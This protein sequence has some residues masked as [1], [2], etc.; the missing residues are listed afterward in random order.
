MIPCTTL[1]PTFAFPTM[2][3]SKQP[4][5]RVP[6]ALT[7]A[8]TRFLRGQ[9]HQLKTLLQTG[10]KGLTD[11]FL[12]EAELALEHHELIKV[13]VAADDRDSRD[14]VIAELTGRTGAALVQRIGHVAILY[15]PSSDRRRIVLPRA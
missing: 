4:E 14:A 13:K 11:V 2:T 9:A 7:S 15:R 6:V 12:A 8:Q 3:A 10:D 1:I 5:T